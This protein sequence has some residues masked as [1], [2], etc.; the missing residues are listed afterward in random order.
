MTLMTIDKE[1]GDV[2]ALTN[3][4][5]FWSLSDHP[6]HSQPGLGQAL[7]R[8]ENLMQGKRHETKRE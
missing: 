6:Q 5:T 4:A 2:N 7:W 3:S 1:D 8:W